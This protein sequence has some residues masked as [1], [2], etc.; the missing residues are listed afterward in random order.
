MSNSSYKAVIALFGAIISLLVLPASAQQSEAPLTTVRYASWGPKLV[1]QADFFVAEE[2]GYFK[3]E[4]LSVQW[5]TAQG[6][7]DALRHVIAGNADPAC[8]PA[9]GPLSHRRGKG[10]VPKTVNQLPR[11]RRPL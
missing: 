11:P 6:N 4:G 3:D 7:G 5:I 10:R 1:D 2:L 9:P 8:Q